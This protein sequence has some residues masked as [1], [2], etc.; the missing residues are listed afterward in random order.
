MVVIDQEDSREDPFAAADIH[1][2]GRGFRTDG[3]WL[4]LPALLDAGLRFVSRTNFGKVEIGLHHAAACLL[5]ISRC[6]SNRICS[7]SFK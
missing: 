6:Y 1:L 3:E 2:P 5:G 4:S 7:R